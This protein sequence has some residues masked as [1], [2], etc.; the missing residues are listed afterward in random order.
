[1]FLMNLTDMYV[2]GPVKLESARAQDGTVSGASAGT[3]WPS[4]LL[5]TFARAQPI[6]AAIAAAA[7]QQNDLFNQSPNIRRSGQGGRSPSRPNSR[8]SC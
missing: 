4:K 3:T 8:A 1:M 7:K 5:F 2:L 6:A